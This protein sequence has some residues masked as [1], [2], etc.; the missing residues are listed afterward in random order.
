MSVDYIFKTLENFPR[1]LTASNLRDAS[2]FGKTWTQVLDLLEK[3]LRMLGCRRGSVVIKTAHS[4]YDLRK[5][6]KLRSDVRRPIHPG[7]VLLFDVYDAKA[8]K[9]KP[10][11]F[12]CDQFTEWKANVRAIADGLEALRKINRY[13]VSGGGSLSAHYQGYKALPPVGGVRDDKVADII[14]A[15]F[16]EF[17][18]AHSTFKAQE[19]LERRDVFYRA[20]KQAAGKLHPDN[21]AT[22]DNK[23]FLHLQRIK[24]LLEKIFEK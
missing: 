4:S 22:G 5:D 17:I 13:G 21:K 10:M 15:E 16:A 3:E 23:A 14:L 19:I 24:Q 6:G 9:Y 20:Y 18:D 12:E 11:N 8:K 7:V 2:P 1:K